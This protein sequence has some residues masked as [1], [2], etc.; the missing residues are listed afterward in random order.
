MTGEDGGAPDGDN[1]DRDVAMTHV[2]IN[3]PAREPEN[4]GAPRT[5][6]TVPMQ[7]AL[8]IGIG[9][10][11]LGVGVPLLAMAWVSIVLAFIALAG[12]TLL[13]TGGLDAETIR[14]AMLV[15]F[16]L[17]GFLLIGTWAEQAE[18]AKQAGATHGRRRPIGRRGAWLLAIAAL[19]SAA[20]APGSPY[21][22]APWATTAVLT[23]ACYFIVV[24]SAAVWRLADKASDA[25]FRLGRR[26]PY[27]AGLLTG[28][29]LL[30][31]AAGGWAHH[32]G[33][34]REPWRA[35]RAELELGKVKRPHGALDVGL[36]AL[37]L[38]AGETEPARARD[39]TAA[40]GCQFLPGAQG[41]PN[42]DDDC[43]ESLLPTVPLAKGLLR[44]DYHLSPFDADDVAMEALVV[45][46]EATIARDRRRAYFFK[47]ARNQGQRLV[48]KARRQLSCDELPV[49]NPVVQT[50]CTIADDDDT[51][52]RKLG[53]LWE[54][55]L[56]TFDE[57][58]AGV[59]RSRLVDDLSFRDAGRRWKM[60][61]AAAR[62]TFHNAIKKLRRLGLADCF[63][64]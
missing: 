31:G 13:H 55:A 11:V 53:L 46:C 21:F 16:G 23:A 33:L 4:V 62:D 12:T 36:T 64:E 42:A 40:P 34:S 9:V 15:A 25:L 18:A 20:A 24:M 51:R 35:L 28:V 61:E 56:C 48:L 63:R 1:D 14:P 27:A 57:R 60:T 44:R 8:V 52:A 19:T 26:G 5:A 32:E 10:F 17:A 41:G 22:P 7:A 30:L 29:L 37:C 45:T 2:D 54:T 38:G 3:A 6:V 59:I 39:A 58:T 49:D 43:F 47:V 50:T